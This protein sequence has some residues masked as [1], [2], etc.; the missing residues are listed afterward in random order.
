[1]AGSPGRTRS[2]AHAPDARAERLQLGVDVFVAA[3]DLVHAADHRAAL[4]A[5]RG[6]DERDARPDV[7][8]G[9]AGRLAAQPPGPVHERPVR[10]A[11]HHARAHADQLVHEEEPALVHLLVEEHRALRL[12]RRHQRHAHEVGGEGGPRA[13][14]DGRDGVAEIGTDGQRLG[15]GQDEVVAVQRPAAQHEPIVLLHDGAER[16]QPEHVGVDTPAADLV[17]AG[18]LHARL[19]LAREQRSHQHQAAAHPAQEVGV[20]CRRGDPSRAQGDGVGVVAIHLDTEL[21]DQ[22][23]HRPDVGDVGEVLQTHR[24]IGAPRGGDQREGGV[25]VAARCDRPLEGHPALDDELVHGHD[26]DMVSEA[27]IRFVNIIDTHIMAGGTWRIRGTDVEFDTDASLRRVVE[28]VRRLQP[29]PAFAVL[30]GDLASPD[31]L[32]RERTLTPAEY[33]PSYARLREILGELPCRAHFL[34]GNHDNLEAFNRA[35]RPEASVP[36]G[37]CYYSFD[38]DGT[39][40]IALD[41]HEPGHAD[42]VL[43]PAQLAWLARDLAAHRDTPTIVFIHHH[44]WPLGHAWM[45]TMTLR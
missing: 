17:A 45:D 19:T 1:M 15:R 41:S 4:G 32:H 40:L 28:T 25:L 3:I 16:L 36:D 7:G 37:P 31:I 22:A 26:D 5:E 23:E 44:P 24:L 10:V 34:M 18:A 42:G 13:V 39:H 30:G 12:R 38:H 9:D 43:D 33:A 2:D 11:E 6:H 27:M 21:L 8:A 14:V 29:A 20:R 35:L